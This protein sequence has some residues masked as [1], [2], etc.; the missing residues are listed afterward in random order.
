MTKDAYIKVASL[1][2]VPVNKMYR[3]TVA[4]QQI[5]IANVDGT[6]YAVD[7]QCSH[8]DASLYLGAL[9]GD[10]IKCPLH[11]SRFDLKTGQPLDD[12][13]DEAIQTYPVRQTDT[14]IYISLATH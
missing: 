4:N 6:L 5:L 3:A 14:D 11:G 1:H 13:A 8:E 7:D 2:Q 9:K 12:P 10:C